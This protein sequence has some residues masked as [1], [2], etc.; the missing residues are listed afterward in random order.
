M[1]KITQVKVTNII[2]IV[3]LVIGLVWTILEF[4][5]INKQGLSCKQ[6]PFLYGAEE[7]ATKMNSTISC[8]CNMN[9]GRGGFAFNQTDIIPLQ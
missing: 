9:V 5:D 7:V 1:D 4:R 3:L 6:H 8:Y 2:L